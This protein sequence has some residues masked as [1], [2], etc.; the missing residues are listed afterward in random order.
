MVVLCK[1][2]GELFQTNIT[3]AK[4]ENIIAGCLKRRTICKSCEGVIY[5]IQYQDGTDLEYC[6]LFWELK[7]KDEWANWAGVQRRAAECFCTENMPYE[8]GCCLTARRESLRNITAI[9]K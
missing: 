4:K 5:R 1:V 7:L 8:E 3:L 9:Q 6:I 2:M